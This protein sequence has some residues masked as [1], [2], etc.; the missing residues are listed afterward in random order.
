[1]LTPEYYAFARQCGATHLVIHMVDYFNQAG[2]AGAANRQNQPVNQPGGCWGLAGDPDTFWTLEELSAIKADIEAAGL[3]LY[4][5][6]N[7][8]P[9]H[10]YDILLGGPR[11][12]EQMANVQHMIR[13]V[14]AAGIPVIGYNFS[15]AGVYGRTEGPYARGNAESVGMEGVV[16]RDPIPDGIVWNMRL[17]DDRAA[18]TSVRACCSTEELWER[19]AWFLERALPVAEEAGVRLALHP[20]DPPVERLRD[21]PRLVITPELYQRVLDLQPSP[22]NALEF[23]LGTLAEMPTGDVHEATETYAAQH[24]IAYVH[25]RN[26]TGHAPHYQEQFVDEGDIDMSRIVRIL[27]EANF[28]GVLIPDHT[29]QMTCAAPWHAGMAH[30]LGYMNALLKT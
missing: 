24:K 30:A 16:D 7:F 17:P 12:E 27:R 9:A 18:G 5:I 21:T 3:E 6:E 28:D 10:W 2:D 25:F 11:R 14:G 8:D 19:Y 15:I 20:D 22:A 13:T 1:M 26:I 29:P 4:A 23:C